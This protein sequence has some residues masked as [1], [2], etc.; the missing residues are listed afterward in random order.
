MKRFLLLTLISS[1]FLNLSLAQPF[2]APID[3]DLNTGNEPYEI[4]TADLDGDGDLDLVIGTYDFGASPQ[5]DFVKWYSNDGNGNFSLESTITD[6]IT[7]IEGLGVGDLDGQFGEDIVVASANQNKISLFLSDGSGGF[8]NEI[9]LDSALNGVGEIIVADMNSDGNLDVAAVSFTD[10]KTV[11]YSNDGSANFSAAIDIESGSGNNPYYMDVADFDGDTDMDVVV[12]YFS[13]QSIEIFY[14]QFIESGTNT[15]SWIQDTVTVED[16]VASN[17]RH[18]EVRFADANNDG[19][20]DVVKLDNSGV[21][22]EVSWYDKTING[23]SVENVISPSTIIARPGA[24]EVVDIDDDGNNDIIVTDGSVNSDAMIYFPG[25]SNASFD[26]DEV[27]ITN[28]NWINYDISVADFDSDGDLD[29]AFIGNNNAR[30]AIY[31]NQRIN[32]SV[33]NQTLEEVS[34]YPNPTSTFLN[35]A[36][37]TSGTSNIQVLDVIGKSVINTTISKNEKIDVSHLE[38]GIYLIKIEN[39]SNTFK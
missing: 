4:E 14:N 35:I 26:T 16:E 34:I 37:L 13:T 2:S 29:I 38:N 24:F 23:A 20:M 27:V 9:I 11:W 25:N 18:L 12:S 3:V 21:N 17:S 5:L 15:V 6:D 7:Y 1:T 39:Y 28:N 36:G 19:N 30:L 22:G 31:D 32:L 33:D 8:G 10:D